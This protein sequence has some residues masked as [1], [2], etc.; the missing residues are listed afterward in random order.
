MHV[1]EAV[2]VVV[3]DVGGGD[4]GSGD[5]GSVNFVVGNDGTRGVD[6]NVVVGVDAFAGIW[7][8]HKI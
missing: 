3:V 6:V 7:C 2:V 4:V 5:G 1:T 8:W